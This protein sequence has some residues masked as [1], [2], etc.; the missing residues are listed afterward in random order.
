MREW[1]LL[2]TKS[3]A[4][5]CLMNTTVNV[6]FKSMY[7]KYNTKTGHFFHCSDDLLNKINKNWSFFKDVSKISIFT[8]GSNFWNGASSYHMTGHRVQILQTRAF[9]TQMFHF[10]SC[11]EDRKLQIHALPVPNWIAVTFYL[12]FLTCDPFET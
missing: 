4:S 5:W 3:C 11:L 1:Y 10:F 12:L 6:M 8:R 9:C 7:E 2:F